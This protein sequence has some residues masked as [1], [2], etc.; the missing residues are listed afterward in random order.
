MKLSRYE[1]E[2]IINFNEDEPV[3]SVYTYNVKLKNRLKMLAEKYPDDCAF[4][5][6]NS[7]GGVTY[8]I[9]KKLIA[10]RL[11]Y[12]EERRKRDRERALAQ[13]LTVPGTS[14]R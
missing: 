11:P 3:A 8:I 14:A 7:E 2:T 9:N 5:R 1:Q 10:I 6:K 12:S 13:G 4:E